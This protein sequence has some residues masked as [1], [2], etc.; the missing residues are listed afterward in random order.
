MIRAVKRLW[1]RIRLWLF[2]WL[3]G[4]GTVIVNAQIDFGQAF[5][6]CKGATVIFNNTFLSPKGTEVMVRGQG[7]KTIPGTNTVDR[8]R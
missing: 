8:I 5:I 3:A 1:L 2:L 7:W 6:E 4:N